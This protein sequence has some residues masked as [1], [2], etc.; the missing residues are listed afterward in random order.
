[1]HFSLFLP[2]C[3][4]QQAGVAYIPPE[5]DAIDDHATCNPNVCVEQML[6]PLD[7]D[8]ITRTIKQWSTFLLCKPVASLRWSTTTPV[9]WLWMQASVGEYEEAQVGKWAHS[10]CKHCWTSMGEH[11]LILPTYA[12]LC[13]AVLYHIYILLEHGINACCVLFLGQTSEMITLGDIGKMSCSVRN[14]WL[15][16]KKQA[17]VIGAARF[18]AM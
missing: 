11:S 14:V 1:M 18:Y 7:C 5:C 9:L 15:A 3:N 13:L 12:I 17:S 6:P 10:V 16:E 2:K 8:L 4:V